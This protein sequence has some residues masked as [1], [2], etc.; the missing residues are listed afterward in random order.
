MAAFLACGRPRGSS[1]WP[2]LWFALFA[3]CQVACLFILNWATPGVYRSKV[4]KWQKEVLGQGL[5]HLPGAIG[6]LVSPVY[7]YK[8]GNLWA[9]EQAHLQMLSTEN[10]NTD[11][12]ATMLFKSRSDERDSRRPASV[13]ACICGR[14]RG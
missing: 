13:L 5:Q 10:I 3:A 7:F 8:K 1:A 11:R 4:L 2:P 6:V 14:P 12:M 9:C